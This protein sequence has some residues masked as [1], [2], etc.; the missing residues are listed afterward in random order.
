MRV[1]DVLRV[2][3][4]VWL[5][6]EDA[7]AR[8]RRAGRRG[9]R[10]RPGPEEEEGAVP[11]VGAL[12]GVRPH[13]AARLGLQTRLRR[14]HIC[15][16]HAAVVSSVVS[17]STSYPLLVRSFMEIAAWLQDLRGAVLQKEPGGCIGTLF[18]LRVCCS[19]QNK[20]A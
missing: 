7:A 8:R 10:H 18:N 11:D 20:P 19:A 4:R 3:G 2:A 6:R 1:V 9:R 14:P 17:L 12:Q 16:T 13:D 5:G 15:W